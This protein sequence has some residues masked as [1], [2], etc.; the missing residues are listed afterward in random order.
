MKFSKEVKAALIAI[1][2]IVSFVIFFQFIKGKS[3]FSSDNHFFVKYDNVDGLEPS[4]AVV[5]NGL[6]VGMVDKIEPITNKNGRIHFVAKISVSKDFS[7]SKNS[8]VEI[9]EPGLM[10]GKQ[11]RIRLIYDGKTAQS[12]DTL[13]GAYQLSMMNSISSQVG[14]VKDQ[15][16]SVL[17][18]LDSTVASTNKIVDEQNRREIKMLLANLN[19]TVSSFKSTSEQTNRLLSGNEGRIQNVLENANKTMISANSA[20]DKYGKIAENIDT[21]QLNHTVEKLNQVSDKLNNVISG[22]QNG[23][24]SLG[25]LAK[26]E[27]LYNNLN[28]TSQSLDALIKD[29]KENPKRYINI[30]VFGKSK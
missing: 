2:A 4:N 5:I 29:L 6:K 23:E 24:G 18:K 1:L 28:K 27:E 30:S 25:K 22:I 13:K 7:F 15:L 12:G 19:Q 21:K 11:L 9:F 8:P 3:F 20:V 10:S 17:T 26:D 16:Q 14:P